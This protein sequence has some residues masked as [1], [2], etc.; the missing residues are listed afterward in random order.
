MLVV[1]EVGRK[2]SGQYYC[3]PAIGPQHSVTVHVL[4]RYTDVLPVLG[5]GMYVY[6]KKGW[7]RNK[8]NF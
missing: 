7:P 4:D 3:Q 8:V 6:W 2:D 5:E 1:K